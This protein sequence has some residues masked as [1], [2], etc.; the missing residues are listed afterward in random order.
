MG[1]HPSRPAVAGRLERSTRRLGRAALERLRRTAADRRPSRPCSGWGLPSHTGHP[2]CGGLLHRRFTLTSASAGGFFSVA[3]SRGSPRVAVNDHPALWSPD[4]PRRRGLPRRRDRPADSVHGCLA[5]SRWAVIHLGLPL[6]AGSSGLPAGSGGPPS[7]AC[8]GRR[9]TAV[10]LDLAPGGVYRA[11]PVTRC[12]VV[13][14]TAVSPLPARA[15]AVCS[16]WHCPAG[17]PGSPLATTLPCGART[18]LGDG[19]S[20]ADATARVL[21]S[22]ASR[23]PDGRS[24][25]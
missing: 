18:F 9:R 19:V 14:Y 13:S 24:S 8:A 15:L 16:L 21:S 25:I 11:T 2:V 3:L 5:A 22:G 20:P 4:V 6:P 7:N 12:A 17:H 1:G 23:P 10:P